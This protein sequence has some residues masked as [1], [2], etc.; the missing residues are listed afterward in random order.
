MCSLVAIWFDWDN[1][2]ETVRRDW[3]WEPHRLQHC[4]PQAHSFLLLPLTSLKDQKNALAFFTHFIFIY[5]NWKPITL[6]YCSGFAIHWHESATG[7]HV[8]PILNPPPLP[9][10]SHPSGSSQCSGPEHLVSCIEPGLTTCFI[11]GNTHVSVLFSQII[12]PLLSPTESKRLF[13]HLCPFCCLTYRVIVTIFLNSI[14]M[15]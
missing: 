15:C 5:F 3:P 1:V 8:S 14:Y 12:P 11:Y 9:S 6:Q 13:L 4:P 2:S 10:P 7:V